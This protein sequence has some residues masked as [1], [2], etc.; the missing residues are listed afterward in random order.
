MLPR[1]LQMELNN[2]S[3]DDT[4]ERALPLLVTSSRRAVLTF[5]T[6]ILYIMARL[7]AI[8]TGFWLRGYQSNVLVRLRRPSSVRLPDYI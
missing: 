8:L 1:M 6:L 4:K 5:T 3:N 7:G 2:T